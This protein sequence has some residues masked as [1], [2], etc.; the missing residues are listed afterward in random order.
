VA[1]SLSKWMFT[2]SER[3]AFPTEVFLTFSLSLTCDYDRIDTGGGT[4]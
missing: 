4:A 2:A 1:S 3:T